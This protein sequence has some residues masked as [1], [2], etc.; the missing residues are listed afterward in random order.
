MKTKNVL[1]ITNRFPPV[2]GP[3][4]FRILQFTKYLKQYGY[5]TIVLTSKYNE[6]YSLYSDYSLLKELDESQKIIRTPLGELH[7]LKDIL[8]KLKLMRLFRFFMYPLFWEPEALWPYISLYT[9][10]KEINKSRISIIYTTSPSF[11]TLILGMMLKFFNKE[12]IW[13][14]ELRD[15]FTDGYMWHWPSKIHWYLCRIAEYIILKKPDHIIVPTPSLRSIYLK[16]K[17]VHDN[18]ISVVTNGYDE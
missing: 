9:A 12:L 13:V 2:V 18:K 5:N 14:A 1:F 3:G 11:S 7:K 8:I 10:Q 6:H 15:P 17:I 4:S 16:R